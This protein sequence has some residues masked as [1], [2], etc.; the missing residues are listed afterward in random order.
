MK[1]HDL[2]PYFLVIDSEAFI[3]HVAPYKAVAS[4][5]LPCP[6]SASSVPSSDM[7]FYSVFYALVGLGIVYFACGKKSLTAQDPSVS[8]S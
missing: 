6:S 4:R 8:P 5:K 1:L 3:A 7:T 2:P